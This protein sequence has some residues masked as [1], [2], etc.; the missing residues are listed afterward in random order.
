MKQIQNKGKVAKKKSGMSGGSMVALG[1]TAAALAG[2]AYYLLGPKGKQHQKSAKKWTLD[3]KKQITAK[4]KKTK[5]LSEAAYKKIIDDVAKVY[6]KKGAAI[7]EVKA[8]TGGLKKEWKTIVKIAKKGVKS[9]AF[10]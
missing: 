5:N 1:A 10:N 7:K 8:F 4:V 2:A 6:E 3:A 9:T